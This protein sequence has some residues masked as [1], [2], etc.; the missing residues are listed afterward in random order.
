MFSD[1]P[2]LGDLLN[3]A[4]RNTKR[5]FHT[6]R[7]GV[8]EIVVEAQEAFR[9]PGAPSW[10]QV[11]NFF[12]FIP[13]IWQFFCE[14]YSLGPWQFIAIIVLKFWGS[15]ESGLA[16]YCN[17]RILDAVSRFSVNLKA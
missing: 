1:F 15:L 10:E 13:Y 17:G 11:E 12:S 4:E 9:L 7:L 5:R 16:I 8:W 3:R 14:I 2:V 6:V